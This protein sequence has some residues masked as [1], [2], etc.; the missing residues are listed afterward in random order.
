MPSQ[1][2][3][4]FVAVA[5]N[6]NFTAYNQQVDRTFHIAEDLPANGYLLIQARGVG[7]SNH[8]IYINEKQLPGMDIPP[9]SDSSALVTS[10]DIIPNNFLQSGENKLTI[11]ANPA[12]AP[13]P[14]SIV[15]AP[16]GFF[17]GSVVVNY[18]FDFPVG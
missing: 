9:Q 5:V 4:N 17:I 3:N 11:Y 18:L 7:R 15:T 2:G 14:G 10:M 6:A 1:N 12:A 16:D 8:R 13:A